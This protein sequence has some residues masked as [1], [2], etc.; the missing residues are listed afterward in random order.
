M[1]SSASNVKKFSYQGNIYQFPADATD[2]EVE[3][4]FNTEFANKQSVPENKKDVPVVDDLLLTTLKKFEGLSLKGIPDAQGKVQV[5]YGSTGR[6]ELGE[7][8]SEEEAERFLLEDSGRAASF[9]EQTFPGLDRNQKAAV[10]SLVF[11]IGEGRFKNS[12]AF[13]ALKAGDEATFVKEAFDKDVGFVKADGKPLRGLI[14]R[15]AAER[16]LFQEA[17]IQRK[18]DVEEAITKL[19]PGTYVIDGEL[20]EVS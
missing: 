7:T 3:E 13:K 19:E 1:A 5:G 18:R 11:N 6:V 12:K 14:K 2:E 15:R 16:E 17:A 4:F 9:V 8:I 10:S 20:V